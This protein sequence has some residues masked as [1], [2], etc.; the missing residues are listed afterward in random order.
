MT[1]AARSYEELDEALEE[2]EHDLPTAHLTGPNLESKLALHEQ[3]GVSSGGP[4]GS[5]ASNTDWLK[6]L[7]GKSADTEELPD[8][9][10]APQPKPSGMGAHSVAPRMAPTLASRTASALK[11]G[12]LALVLSAVAVAAVVGGGYVVLSTSWLSALMSPPADTTVENPQ[13][14]QPANGSTTEN[15]AA[16]SARQQ[17]QPPVAPGTQVTQ[18]AQAVPEAAPGGMDARTLRDMGIDQYKAGKFNEAIAL[19]ESAVATGEGDAVA[20]YQLGLAYMAATGREQGLADAELAFR[21]A[22]SLQPDWG[23]PYQL[24]AESLLRR[25]HFKEAIAPAL[26]ATRLEPLQAD[27][28]LTL[29]R[30][31]QG[32]GQTVEATKA[33][34]EATR[35][36][37]DPP[38]P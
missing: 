22:I 16:P 34:A 17:E 28:W 20:Y 15:P 32:N 31:Y 27:T 19:L 29:G 33:F 25:G 8:E 26:E 7:A 24:L 30:A 14:S 35:L 11:R 9:P 38:Q 4:E 37:P 21:S 18:E 2:N 5:A 36:A 6:L 12:T 1:E 13:L 3:P 10:P 23:A